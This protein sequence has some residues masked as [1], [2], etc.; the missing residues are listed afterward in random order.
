[1]ND[2][3]FVNLRK[4]KRNLTLFVCVIILM[5]TACER[6]NSIPLVATTDSTRLT[7]SAPLPSIYVSK[8]VSDD[9]EHWFNKNKFNL[10][11]AIAKDYDAPGE[12]KEI[13]LNRVKELSDL[14]GAFL[15]IKGMDGLRIYFAT[16]GIKQEETEK[17]DI[18][19]CGR[20]NFIFVCTVNKED[21]G[22][23]YRVKE[24]EVAQISEDKARSWVKN[25]QM[26]NGKRDTLKRTL[27]TADSNLGSLETK[28]VWFDRDKTIELKQEIDYQAKDAG[29]KIRLVSYTDESL[30][31]GAFGGKIPQKHKQRLTIEFVFTDKHGSDVYVDDESINTRKLLTLIDKSSFFLEKDDIWKNLLTLPY[32][33]KKWNKILELLN[34]EDY[35][36]LQKR[37]ND[38]YTMDTGDPTP[39]P[40]S[41]NKAALDVSDQ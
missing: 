13:R 40:S 22:N 25:Y 3:K 29:L 18:D 26:T 37:I 14:I 4:K 8:D 20:F 12:L 5:L 38:Y 34:S 15:K 36:S 10:L 35:R 41:G 6:K 28:H 33:E 17:E 16:R 31:N 32:S 23:Y 21:Y 11:N 30:I 39:P 9:R 19:S 1:M 24:G 7:P 27:S 2:L